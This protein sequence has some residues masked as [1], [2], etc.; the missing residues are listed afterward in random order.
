[1]EN[2]KLFAA[3]ALVLVAGIG[4]VI[5]ALLAVG[6]ASPPDPLWLIEHLTF[7]LLMRASYKSLS[8]WDASEWSLAFARPR[9]RVAA[10]ARSS[11]GG[12]AA[13]AEA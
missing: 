8:G 1:M 5:A 9:V 4:S 3:Y 13:G 7:S 10:A 2:D 6:M 11:L 12:G